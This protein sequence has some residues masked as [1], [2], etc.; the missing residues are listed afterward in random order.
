M[1]KYQKAAAVMAMLGSASFL[2]AGVGHASDG[3]EAELNNEQ[4]TTCVQDNSKQG[5]INIDD[6]NLAV[7]IL[8]LGNA[9]NTETNSVACASSSAIGDE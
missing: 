6:I 7:G 3:V 2:G 5:L 1:R 8:G 9:E 4:T